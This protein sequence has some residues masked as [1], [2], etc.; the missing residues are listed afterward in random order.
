[1]SFEKITKTD[2]DD[3]RPCMILVNFD[4][5]EMTTIKSVSTF[6]GIRD[7]IELNGKHGKCIISDIIEGKIE[8]GDEKT[9]SNKAVIFNNI[10]S[11]KVSG[12]IDGL[13]KMRMRRPYTAM[14][15]ET[16]KNWTL[17]VLIQNLIQENQA[18]ASGKEAEHG[19]I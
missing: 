1:M 5:K 3:T 14:V 9:F 16:S 13:K 15:T 18:L 6:T 2:N 8:P 7:R 11:R 12:F 10:D 17:E 4:K 19:E